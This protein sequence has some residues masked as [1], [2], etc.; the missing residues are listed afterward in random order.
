MKT[1]LDLATSDEIKALLR[2]ATAREEAVA[3]NRVWKMRIANGAAIGILA[4]EGVA[5]L[6]ALLG[7]SVLQTAVT[8]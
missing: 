4:C 6:S 1:A 8:D 5:I 2:R 7:E 3:R